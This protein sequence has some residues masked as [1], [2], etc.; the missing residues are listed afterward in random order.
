MARKKQKNE[1]EKEE[2][3]TTDENGIKEKIERKQISVGGQSWNIFLKAVIDNKGDQAVFKRKLLTEEINEALRLYACFYPLFTED[4]KLYKV[5]EYRRSKIQAYQIQ[6]EYQKA[7][8]ESDEVQ[9]I[10]NSMRDF[11][12]PNQKYRFIID[13]C[14]N[15]R[16]EE[17]QKAPVTFKIILLHPNSSGAYFR[18]LTEEKDLALKGE[19]KKT[20]F[21][22]DL[23]KIIHE[24]NT[25]ES[26]QNNKNFE[27]RFSKELLPWYAILTKRL[28][29]FEPY[30]SASLE[31]LMKSGIT[32]MDTDKSVDCLGGYTPYF[33][34]Y[35][36]S[37]FSIMMSSHFEVMWNRYKNET[38][39]SALNS[40]DDKTYGKDFPIVN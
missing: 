13:Q 18:M 31:D 17:N 4:F 39:E 34:F 26:F 24:L 12:L 21:Y 7:M 32:I 38:V 15:R 16:N 22:L 35:R 23:E 10:G 20:Q 33:C 27:V 5:F 8:L 25:H 9:L 2:E 11:L 14:L 30:H 37:V 28:S 36:E 3:E 1:K 40:L 29:F 19:F 6:N